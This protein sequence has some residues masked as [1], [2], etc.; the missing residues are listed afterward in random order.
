MSFTTRALHPL[1]ASEVRGL[2][3][4]QPLD[5][6]IF[7]AVADLFAHRGVLVIRGQGITPAQQ[8][9]FSRGFGPLEIH[10]LREFLLPGHP[11]ILV[12]SNVVENGRHIGLADA[13]RYWHSDLSYKAEPSLGSALL[14]RELPAEGGDTLFASQ[15]AAFDRLPAATRARLEGLIAEHDYAQRNAALRAA[16]GVR[17]ELTAAQRAEVPAVVHPVVV[18]HPVT[19]RPA[20]FV[21]RGFTTRILDLPEADSRALLDDLFAAATEEAI[22]Y[23]HR[24]QPGDLVLWD[25]RAVIHLATPVPTGQRR[26]MHRTTVRG[27]VPRAARFTHEH[28]LASA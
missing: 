15:H 11:E 16:N 27:T 21:N 17:P 12:V 1:F 20:L 19:G 8:I 10:V 14:A 5:E 13:G 9:A 26:T 22:I 23:R 25:N 28:V 2:D 4:S 7:A 6:A 3:L 18:A 24:W